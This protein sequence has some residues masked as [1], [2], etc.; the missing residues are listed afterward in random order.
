MHYLIICILSFFA[1]IGFYYFCLGIARVVGRTP[2]DGGIFLI[3]PIGRNR[4]DAEF[5]LRNA[6]GRVLR[7]GRHAP[8]K[9]FCL[10]C[11]MDRDTRKICTLIAR[12]YSFLEIISKDEMKEKL[13]KIET[14]AAVRL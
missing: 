5:V 2:Q 13:E 3:E 7:M 9:V 1:V 12:D 11:G 8:E 6:V 14:G 4:R 10:D